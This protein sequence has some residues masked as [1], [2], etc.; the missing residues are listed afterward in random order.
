[1]IPVGSKL[2]VG[3]GESQ[4]EGHIGC[5]VRDL[6]TVGLVS[7]AWEVSRQCRS[8]QE[9]YSRQMLEHLTLSEA[10]LTL[11]D[12]FQA[13]AVGGRVHIVVPYFNF[14]VEQ[15]LPAEWTEESPGSKWS[16]ARWGFHSLFGWQRSC[17]PTTPHYDSSYWDVH[18]SG[19]NKQLITFLFRRA[20]FGNMKADVEDRCH[21]VAHATKLRED[22]GRFAAIPSF[23][24]T[25]KPK[26][27]AA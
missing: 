6:P 11:Y 25:A 5:D 23:G 22:T 4:R 10:N 18:K 14:H 24:V 2:D 27:R 9:I 1:M 16:D 21:L 12:W 7:K 26:T 3:F 13:L 20:G 15:I 8:L 17:D 19:F